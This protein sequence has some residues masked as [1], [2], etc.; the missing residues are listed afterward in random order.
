M[1][2]YSSERPLAGPKAEK[3]VSAASVPSSL[4]VPRLL[5]SPSS[6]A[7]ENRP[8]R[9]SRR[10]RLSSIFCRRISRSKLEL[11]ASSDEFDI[12]RSRTFRSRRASA[13]NSETDRVGLAVPSFDVGEGTSVMVSMMGNTG[14]GLESGGD[15]GDWVSSLSRSGDDPMPSDLLLELCER[16]ESIEDKDGDLR[17]DAIARWKLGRLSGCWSNVGRGLGIGD[18]REPNICDAPFL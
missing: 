9:D 11:M 15:F 16:P 13:A 14:G 10:K 12:S 6:G 1:S 8:A 4:T 3:S 18:G 5:R 2:S 17:C 7:N